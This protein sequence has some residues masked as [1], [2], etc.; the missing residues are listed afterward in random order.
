MLAIIVQVGGRERGA[1]KYGQWLGSKETRVF[2]LAELVRA[3]T[4]M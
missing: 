1:Y 3:G 2:K 4:V